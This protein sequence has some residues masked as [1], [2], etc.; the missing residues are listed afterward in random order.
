MEVK[1]IR[2]RKKRYLESTERKMVTEF[3]ISYLNSC[4]QG[5]DNK[6]NQPQN[7]KSNW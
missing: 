6:L 4:I 7:K 5:V 2:I 1:I 3:W